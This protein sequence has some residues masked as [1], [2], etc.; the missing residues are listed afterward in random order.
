MPL[1]LLITLGVGALWLF[2]SGQKQAQAQ[3]QVQGAA[4]GAGGAAAAGGPSFYVGQ[5]VYVPQTDMFSDAALTQNAGQWPGG[6]ATIKD[7]QGS[8][9]GFVGPSGAG[10]GGGAPAYVPASIVQAA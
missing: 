1:W 3:G 9:I 5:S 6:T 8:S 2:A 4:L 7:I 10:L